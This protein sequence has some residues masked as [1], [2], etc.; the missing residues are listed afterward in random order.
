MPVEMPTKK[1]RNALEVQGVAMHFHFPAMS[2]QL[3]F[4]VEIIVLA[5]SVVRPSDSNAIQICN[6]VTTVVVATAGRTM[7]RYVLTDGA[8]PLSN[9]VQASTA[10]T[11]AV[12]LLDVAVRVFP[13]SPRTAVTIHVCLSSLDVF[14]VTSDKNH[15]YG[16]NGY[17]VRQK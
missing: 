17:N 3:L 13:Q 4:V 11:L 2:L 5:A 16:I 7:W 9:L 10:D 6:R 14:S 8:V 12:H 1:P 15:K